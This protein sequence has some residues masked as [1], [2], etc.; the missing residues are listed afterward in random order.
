M[1]KTQRLT[2]KQI[3]N[4]VRR[5]RRKKKGDFKQ[6]L[7]GGRRKGASHHRMGILPRECCLMKTDNE[8]KAFN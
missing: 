8:V 4:S 2:D 3:T 5:N 1:F 6:K 7:N